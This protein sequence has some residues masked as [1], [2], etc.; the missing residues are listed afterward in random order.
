MNDNTELTA[1]ELLRIT[2]KMRPHAQWKWFNKEFGVDLP[3]NGESVIISRALWE[4]LQA[5][6]AGLIADPPKNDRPRIY[7]LKTV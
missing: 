1:V 5:R 7:S 3:R 2:G 6:R 4:Q